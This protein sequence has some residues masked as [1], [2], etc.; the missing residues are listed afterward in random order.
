MQRLYGWGKKNSRV[1]APA[2]DTRFE[3]I[4][5]MGALGLDGIRA[6]FTFDGTLNTEIF[7]PYVEQFLA[8]AMKKDDIF[9][10]DNCSVHKVK[11]SLKPLIDK[12]IIVLFLPPY[13][14][15]FNPIEMSWSKIKSYLRKV[16]AE[17]KA[18]LNDALVCAFDMFSKDEI[19]NWFRHD[20]Y[21]L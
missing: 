13:S 16:C 11:N 8:P 5:V 2:K 4:S 21:L 3:R 20:G 1:N 12:G 17:T 10:L 9:I 14:P 15:D 18:T 6:P 19:I 7:K